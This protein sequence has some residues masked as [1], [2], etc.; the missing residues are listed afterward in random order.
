MICEIQDGKIVDVTYETLVQKKVFW[1][2]LSD[3]ISKLQA[4]ANGK[5]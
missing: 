1:E 5:G 3:L 4:T 2:R